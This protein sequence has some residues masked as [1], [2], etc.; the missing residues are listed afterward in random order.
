MYPPPPQF[1][2]EAILKFMLKTKAQSFRGKGSDG[3]VLPLELACFINTIFGLL[4]L[5]STPSRGGVTTLSPP[6]PL[7]LQTDNFVCR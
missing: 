7:C 3:K 2:K 6:S 1:P 4:Q 5:C